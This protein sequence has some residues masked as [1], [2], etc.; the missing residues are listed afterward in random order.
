MTEAQLTANRANSQLSTG[1]TSLTGKTKVSLNAVK[2]ALTGRT[3]LL[4]SED[5]A[6]YERHIRAYQDE[7]KPV[8]QLES[9]LAQGIADTAWRLA[10][11]PGLEMA[12]YAQGHLQFANLFEDQDPSVRP[13]L[14]ELHI[15]SLNE[16]RLRNLHLQEAR[17]HRRREKDT[18]ELRQLQQERKAADKQKRTEALEAATRQYFIAKKENRPFD[19]STTMQNGFEFSIDEIQDFLGS[20]SGIWMERVLAS[21]ERARLQAA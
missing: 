14:I 11:I 8:G 21:R 19:P 1:P 9:D 16:Q 20:M 17:L 6:L 15:A 7:L 2:T 4:P 3:V 12:I 5:A 18:A 10:R 13:A